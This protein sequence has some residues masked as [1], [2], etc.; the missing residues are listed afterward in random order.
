MSMSMQAKMFEN[1]LKRKTG[2]LI[3]STREKGLWNIYITESKN[4]K[5]F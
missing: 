4:F 5:K 3:F 1:L 2:F